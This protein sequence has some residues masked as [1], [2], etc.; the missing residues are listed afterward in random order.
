M[1]LHTCVI[2]YASD[3]ELISAAGAACGNMSRSENIGMMAS[4]D[5]TIWFHLPT[6]TRA[7]EW[8]LY[9]TY[10][11]RSSG[12]RGVSFGK[13]FDRQG[14]LIATTAQ[15]GLIRLSTPVQEKFQ[16]ADKELHKE[17]LRKLYF[18]KL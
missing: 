16:N 9:D 10:S 18:N 14:N 11:P 2:A 13:I 15:E 3:N 8:L 17:L 1:R 4:L 7:D 5:H 6:V 12:G